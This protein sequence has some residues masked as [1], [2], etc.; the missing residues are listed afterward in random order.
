MTLNTKFYITTDGIDPHTVWNALLDM[1]EP[2]DTLL[3]RNLYTEVSDAPSW[4]PK[5]AIRTNTKVGIGLNAWC[6]MWHN[7]DGSAITL[8]RDQ[9]DDERKADPDDDYAYVYYVPKSYI[10]LAFDTAYGYRGPHDE[11]CSDLH[12]RIV[13]YLAGIVTVLGGEYAWQDEYTGEWFTDLS[14]VPY[15]G[16]F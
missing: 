13:T 11:G 2:A 15:F 4:G 8:D 6:F 10:R 12:G 3:D 16:R 1:V 7:T 14:H 5:G 9:T